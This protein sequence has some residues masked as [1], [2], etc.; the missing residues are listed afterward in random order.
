M[1]FLPT[2]LK[3]IGG[4]LGVA[5]MLQGAN[6]QEFTSGLNY[7]IDLANAGAERDNARAGL[8][9][10]AAGDRI[11]FDSARA[12]FQL[13]QLDAE[14][15]MRNAERL[16]LFAESTTKQGREAIRR[17][18]R[19]FEEFQG[20]QRTAVAASG[21]EMSGSALEVMAESE[22]RFRTQVEDMADEIGF[23]RK[24]TLDE[25]AL[26]EFGARNTMI[27][28]RAELGFAQRGRRLS[29]IGR[30]I[31]RGAIR[32]Q[33]QSNL[34]SAEMS[35]LSGADQAAGMRAQAFGSALSG[36]GG[37]LTDRY[38]INQLGMK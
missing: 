19:S 13:A 12:N 25:A 9:L 6:S 22:A 26:Q 5:G 4:G 18:V 7:R 15:G 23:A 33:Y 35:L 34:L 38:N 20:T 2:L 28:A 11:T 36:V 37:F 27:G 32:S 24:A 1:I 14:A 31:G 3:A 29:R 30:R 17:Q 10:Q 16:R 21:V 8:R